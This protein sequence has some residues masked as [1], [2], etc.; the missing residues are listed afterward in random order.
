MGAREFIERALR[1]SGD[2]VLPEPR[3]TRT[4]WTVRARCQCA[5]QSPFKRRSSGVIRSMGKGN[6]MVELFSLE[7][8]A[9][10]CR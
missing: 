5:R 3:A 6:T 10:V 9:S 8:S 7:M 4:R 2:A 1:S